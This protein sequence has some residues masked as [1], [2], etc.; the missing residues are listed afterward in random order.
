MQDY[1]PS[2]CKKIVLEWNYFTPRLLLGMKL[3]HRSITEQYAHNLMLCY[4]QWW[5]KYDCSDNFFMH[6]FKI[7]TLLMMYEFDQNGLLFLQCARIS[8]AN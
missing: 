8:Y 1:F 2:E 3:V 5:Q 4:T 7:N 6:S